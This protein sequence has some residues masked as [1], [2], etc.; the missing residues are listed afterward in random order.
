MELRLWREHRTV[1]DGK[2]V[3]GMAMGIGG[4]D[5][6]KENITGTEEV[7]AL[8]GCEG[9]GSCLKMLKLPSVITRALLEAY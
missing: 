2:K 3:K 9:K 1:D 4:Q 5:A 7:E 8:S 6:I